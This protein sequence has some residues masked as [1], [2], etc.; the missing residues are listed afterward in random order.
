MNSLFGDFNRDL[1]S[2]MYPEGPKDPNMEYIWFLHIRNRNNDCWNMLCIWVL[3]PLGVRL[4]FPKGLPGIG[5][6]L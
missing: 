1:K 2:C 3:G 5:G 4:R 6:A